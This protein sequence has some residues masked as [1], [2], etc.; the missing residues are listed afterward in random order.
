MSLQAACTQHSGLQADDL[1]ADKEEEEELQPQKP[2]CTRTVLCASGVTLA[3]VICLV[4][5]I[6]LLQHRSMDIAD[7]TGV[8]KRGAGLLLV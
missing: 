1:E 7:S 6:A 2:L 3:A 8:E 4:A 5:I